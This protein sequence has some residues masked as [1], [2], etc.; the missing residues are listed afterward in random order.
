VSLRPLG[1]ALGGEA[2]I[3]GAAAALAGGPPAW[4]VGGAVRDALL[5]RTPLQDADVA[6]AGDAKAAARLLGQALDGAVFELSAEFETWRVTARPGGEVGWSIDVAALR[7]PTIEADLAL[8]DFTLNA[9]AVSLHG[10]GPA[11]EAIDPTGG[12]ADLDAGLLRVVSDAAFDDDPLRLMRLARIGGELGFAPEPGTLSLARERAHRAAEPAGERR[13]AELRMML[14]GSDPLRTL[15][16]LDEAELTPVVMPEVAA[17]R[18]VEQSA[19]HHLDVH[20]HTIEVLRRWLDIERDIPAYAGDAAE[21]VEA[22]LAQPLADGLTRRD[23]IRFATIL[24]DIGKPATRTERDG[25]I[26]FRGHDDV[27]AA[28]IG[29]LC[30][31]LRTSRRF[32]EYEAAIARHHL[33]LGFMTHERPLSRRRIWDYIAMCGREALDVTLLTVADRLSAQGAGV[34]AAAIEAHLDLAR[35]MLGEI[36]VV[37]FDGPPKPLLAGDEIAE[38]LGVVG[39]E[40]GTAVRELAA[41][42]FAGEVSDRAAAERHLREW[43][44]E[45]PGSSR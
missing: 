26:G 8:R 6:V 29:E 28:M 23:G 3:R 31:E 44:S 40:I 32:A 45:A 25:F 35:E 17:L 33:V 16:L 38:L 18:G 10:D 13:W 43:W 7:A 1:D 37:E 4:L 14:A 24:H 36:V 21:R 27:G 19:N 12:L 15:E 9:I 34:P 39:P 2:L 20:D 41:A 22:A 5:G 30:A 42:Q 11:T